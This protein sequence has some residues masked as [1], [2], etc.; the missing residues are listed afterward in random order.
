MSQDEN[1]IF[2]K[3]FRGE[4]PAQEVL[5]TEDVLVFRDVNPKAPQHLLVIPKRHETNLGDFVAAADPAEVGDLFAVGSRAGRQASPGGYRIVVNEG[6][7]AGQ[8]VFHLHLHVLA[9]RAL[10]WPPG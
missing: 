9:G 8:T 3:I 5:R 4:I 2:C 1:C 10:G 6:H 7:D